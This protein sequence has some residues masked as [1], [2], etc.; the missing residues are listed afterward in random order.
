MASL[1]IG[2]GPQQEEKKR[3]KKAITNTQVIDFTV[4]SI[5]LML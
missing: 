3:Y 5:A 2:S 4:E 1:L